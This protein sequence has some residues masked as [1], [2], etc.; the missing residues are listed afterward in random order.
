[1]TDTTQTPVW[2]I[3]GCSTGFGRHLARHTLGLGYPTVVTA[4]HPD[5]VADIAAGHPGLALVLPLGIRVMLVEPRPFR[6]D[7][8]GRSAAEAP[9][10]LAEYDP[11]AGA[12]RAMIRGYSGKQPGDP[13]RAAAAIV[14]A[15]ESARPPLRL[16]LGRM[17]LETARAKLAAVGRDLD[18]WESVTLGADFPQGG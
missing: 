7:W 3:T 12:R 6:T 2:F 13:V 18:D 16:V 9:H 14:Q 10:T 4:R 1:M 15:V 8:A 17:A 5:Q 11:T